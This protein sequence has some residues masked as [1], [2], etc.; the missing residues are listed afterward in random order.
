M[1]VEDYQNVLNL[2]ALQQILQFHDGALT[3]LPRAHKPLI[4]RV[5]KHP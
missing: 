4:S 1:S 5:R 3:S 2:N